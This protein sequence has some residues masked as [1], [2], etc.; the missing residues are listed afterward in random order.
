MKRPL[1]PYI[2]LAP[3]LIGLLVF[4]AGPIV[5]SFLLSFT[6]WDFQFAAVDWCGKLQR[7][8]FI[9]AVLAGFFKHGVLRFTSGSGNYC[10]FFIPCACGEQANQGHCHF[11]ERVFHAGCYFDG[12]GC[13]G[14]GMD[15]QPGVRADKLFAARV[16]WRRGTGVAGRPRVGDAGAGDCGRVESSRLQYDDF[17]R[18]TAA[19]PP[20]YD[21]AARL[22]GATAANA[23]R[24]YAADALALAVFVWW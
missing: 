5:A 13:G 18:R 14:V 11:P 4:S 17:S 19:I 7:D 12:C 23:S 22:D 9:A 2:F 20:E 8:I 16:V 15:V 3:V 21:E 10:A 1:T 6:Q 24:R